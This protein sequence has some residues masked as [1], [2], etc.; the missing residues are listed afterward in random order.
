[1]RFSTANRTPG[2]A[3][4]AGH[5]QA[6]GIVS[7][8]SQDRQRAVFMSATGQR[9]QTRFVLI[10][11]QAPFRDD[12][13]GSGDEMNDPRGTLEQLGTALRAGDRD[14]VMSCFATDAILSVMSGEDRITWKGSGIADAVDA[15]LTGFA[16]LKL[17][18]SSRLVSKER[19]VEEAV[20][21]GDHT[22]VF[23]KADPTSR[24][25]WVNVRLSA[26]WGPDSTLE[27]LR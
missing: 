19:V 6:D 14:A 26:C 5:G 11:R 3:S 27:S 20:V 22:G 12:T 2:G 21:S 7:G 4:T 10:A 13:L 24:R 9:R 23:A 16:D 17:T 1:M 25:V 15:L 18:A 8:R